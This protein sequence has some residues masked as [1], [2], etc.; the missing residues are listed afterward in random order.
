MTE[1][2]FRRQRIKLKKGRIR[3]A[4]SETWDKNDTKDLRR[5]T[6]LKALEYSDRLADE[7]KLKA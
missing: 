1:V 4:F 3:F 7:S 6:V 2:E 5:E